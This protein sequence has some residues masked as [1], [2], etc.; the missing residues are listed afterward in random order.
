MDLWGDVPKFLA[1]PDIAP[2]SKEKL[3]LLL[4][5]KGKELL[6]ELA[7]NVDVGEVFV[8]ATYDLEGDGPLALEC[9]EKIIGFRNSIQVR[10]WPN[11]AAVAKRIATALQPEQYWMSYAG[12]C[13]QRAFDYFEGKFFSGF[14]THY[15]CV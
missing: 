2:N 3:Q 13:V 5:T 10:H 12:N 6:I 9:Y 8:S 1:N 14:H 4:Q 15:G 11:T 7:V